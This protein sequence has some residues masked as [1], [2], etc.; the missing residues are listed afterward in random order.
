M[1]LKI[2]VCNS[3]IYFR[4]ATSYCYVN[5]FMPFFF[6]LILSLFYMLNCLSLALLH[7]QTN[8]SQPFTVIYKILTVNYFFLHSWFSEKTTTCTT[9]PQFFAF[10]IRSMKHK[11]FK[12]YFNKQQEEKQ[13]IIS[14][15]FQSLENKQKKKKTP[16]K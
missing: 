12:S 4:A 2:H 11:S 7:N 10:L 5:P 1:T 13:Y 6:V 15:H 9:S 8:H 16:L 3:F 14:A